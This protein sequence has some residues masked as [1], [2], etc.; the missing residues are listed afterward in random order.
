MQLFAEKGVHILDPAAA[1]CDENG[2]FPVVIRDA[3][4]Y[5]DNDHLTVAGAKRLSHLFEKA[6][7]DALLGE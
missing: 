2:N 3:V 1:L 4:I 6:I 5:Y 7:H